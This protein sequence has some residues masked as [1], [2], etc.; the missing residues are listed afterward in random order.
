MPP[1]L[2]RHDRAPRVIAIGAGIGG[3][4]AAALLARRGYQVRAFVRSGPLVRSSY[5]AGEED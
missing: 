3:L 4:T 1:H 5:H 2:T